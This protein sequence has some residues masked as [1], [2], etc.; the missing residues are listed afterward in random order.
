MNQIHSVINVNLYWACLQA[1]VAIQLVAE[2]DQAICQTFIDTECHIRLF[3]ILE[4]DQLPASTYTCTHTFLVC[5]MYNF[6]SML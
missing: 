2:V 5:F 4:D 3:E 1:C 6:C